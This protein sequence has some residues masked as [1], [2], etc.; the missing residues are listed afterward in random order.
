MRY[1]NECRYV[2]KSLKSS[3]EVLRWSEAARE[4]VLRDYNVQDLVI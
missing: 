1:S 4:E 3:D 2:Y